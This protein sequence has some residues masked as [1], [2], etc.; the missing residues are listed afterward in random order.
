MVCG[1]EWF[2][3]PE[4]TWSINTA[5]TVLFKINDIVAFCQDRGT[6]GDKQRYVVGIDF[7]RHITTFNKLYNLYE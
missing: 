1:S 6:R 3:A 5:E 2:S 7:S 4:E